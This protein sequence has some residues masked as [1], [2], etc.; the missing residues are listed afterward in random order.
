MCIARTCFALY[1]YC[2]LLPYLKE[3][4][5]AKLVNTVPEYLLINILVILVYTC[6]D[7]IKL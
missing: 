6:I 3:R 2:L 7:F 4:G 1:R 5:A